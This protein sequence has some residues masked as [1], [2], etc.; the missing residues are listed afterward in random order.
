MPAAWHPDPVGELGPQASCRHCYR[1]LW[2]SQLAG[3][4]AWADQ[5]GSVI[6]ME[7]PLAAIG[8]GAVTDY[9]THEPMPAGC[10]G[11]PA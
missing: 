2:W 1:S 6:C 11:A 7:S 10:A 5:E 4:W 9:V 8:F 3:R